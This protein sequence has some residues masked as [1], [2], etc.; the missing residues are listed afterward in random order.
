MEEGH[1][2]LR[3]IR[4][5]PAQNMSPYYKLSSMHWLMSGATFGLPQKNNKIH[6][7]C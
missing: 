4:H 7:I 6:R 3:W 1:A 5:D 2:T